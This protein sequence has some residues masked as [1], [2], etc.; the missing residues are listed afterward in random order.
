MDAITNQ[1]DMDRNWIELFIMPMA[2]LRA[3]PAGQPWNLQH[4]VIK[5]KSE[6][7]ERA[8][9]KT[10]FSGEKEA[11]AGINLSIKYFRMMPY[12]I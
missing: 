7:N 1:P 9:M 5:E 4:S 3:V 11:G 8:F 12:N 6:G 2:I 10:S